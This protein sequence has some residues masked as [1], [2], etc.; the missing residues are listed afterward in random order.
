MGAAP[1]SGNYPGRRGCQGLVQPQASS[2]PRKEGPYILEP[3][4]LGLATRRPKNK[5][6]ALQGQVCVSALCLAKRPR[7][8]SPSA[9]AS[10]LSALLPPCIG[11][12]HVTELPLLDA[13]VLSCIERQVH[14]HLMG[15]LDS[16]LKA[17]KGLLVGIN[18]CYSNILRG[19]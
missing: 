9:E 19:G 18:K 5:T 6:E 8:C 10:T 4:R 14:S 12:Q 1:T 2:S 13:S 3:S 7:V 15:T 11:R 17:H 16:W